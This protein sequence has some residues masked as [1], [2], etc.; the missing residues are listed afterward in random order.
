MAVISTTKQLAI[1]RKLTTA[2]NSSPCWQ[3]EQWKDGTHLHHKPWYCSSLATCESV[4]RNLALLHVL[5]KIIKKNVLYK[6]FPSRQ[7]G[8]VWKEKSHP[9]E[10][11]EEKER[12]GETTAPSNVQSATSSRECA[13]QSLTAINKNRSQ[14]TP[15]L[16]S[17]V[18]VDVNPNPQ[19]L[20]L[21]V[22]DNGWKLQR[23][24][25]HPS[26]VIHPNKSFTSCTNFQL[27]V[28]VSLFQSLSIVF[29]F[30][31]LCLANWHY[32]LLCLALPC[33]ANW[34]Y[35]FVSFIFKV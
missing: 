19:T 2:Y 26:L 3:D 33:L 8:I 27:P 16:S 4:N 21:T 24:I 1:R 22:R 18:F 34:H 35:A 23:M 11:Q 25:S 28:W 12:R 29:C 9:K 30:A 5:L 13:P 6:I 31:L 20:I 10:K 7:T 14:K 17:R 15:K 32:A